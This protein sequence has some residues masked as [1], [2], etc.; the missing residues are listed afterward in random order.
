MNPLKHIRTGLLRMSQPELATHL[1]VEGMTVSR[2][3]NGLRSIPHERVRPI[4][5]QLVEAAGHVWTDS[6]LFEAPVCDDCATPG[7]CPSVCVRVAGSAGA[8][9][10]RAPHS[11]AA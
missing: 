4:L 2:W 5:R 6:L 3:E 1:G 8:L 7:G 9:E 11:E 10:A